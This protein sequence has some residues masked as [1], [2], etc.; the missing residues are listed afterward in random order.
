MVIAFMFKAMILL[1]MIFVSLEFKIQNKKL[2]Q[3]FC[4]DLMVLKYNL[5]VFGLK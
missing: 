1:E 2:L 3:Q 5:P 4:F